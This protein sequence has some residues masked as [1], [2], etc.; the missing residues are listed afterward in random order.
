MSQTLRK[1]IGTVL[2]FVLV[3]L[4]ALIAMT[5]ATA[6]LAESSAWVHL[7]YFFVTGILWVLPAMAIVSWMLRRDED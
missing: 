2:L 5:I 3:I 7:L 1:L 4:Y 6:R